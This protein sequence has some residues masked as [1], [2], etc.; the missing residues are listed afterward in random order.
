MMT[1]LWPIK[2]GKTFIDVWSI[3]HLSFWVYAGSLAWS[4]FGLADKQKSRVLALSVCLGLAYLWEVFEY[5]MAPRYPDIWLTPESWFNSWVS[6]PLTCIL[7]VLF[8]WYA[9]DHW[10]A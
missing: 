7:G 8:I 4:L 9:L 3:V 6:D 1:W 10:G 2:T 5:F